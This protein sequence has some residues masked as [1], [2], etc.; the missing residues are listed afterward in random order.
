M[1]GFEAGPADGIVKLI[2][3]FNPRNTVA[4]NRNMVR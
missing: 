2:Q 1:A 4:N 3:L